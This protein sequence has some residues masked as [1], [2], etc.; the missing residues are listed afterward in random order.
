MRVAKN[1]CKC[2]LFSQ[3]EKSKNPFILRPAEGPVGVLVLC[4]PEK[5]F[6]REYGFENQAKEVGYKK[7]PKL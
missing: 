7:R 4:L 5:Y 2:K 6:G 3:K 1:R